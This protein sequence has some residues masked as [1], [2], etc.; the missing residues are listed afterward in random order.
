MAFANDISRR[1]ARIRCLHQCISCLKQAGPLPE[2]LCYVP[3]R[4]EYKCIAGTVDMYP[5]PD[6]NTDP[7]DSMTGVLLSRVIA[8]GH[9][10]CNNQG[11]WIRVKK[12]KPRNCKKFLDVTCESWVLLYGKH[13]TTED[14]PTMEPVQTKNYSLAKFS[15]PFKLSNWEEVV[16][17]HY[18]VCLKK[19]EVAHQDE[20]IMEKLHTVLQNWTLEND[21]ALVQ[22]MANSMNQNS[23]YLGSL[24]NFVDFVDVS[25]YCISDDAGPVNLT[26]DDTG[27]YWESEGSQGQHWIKLQ[28]KKGTIIKKLFLT[29]SGADDIYLPSKVIVCGGEEFNMKELNMVTLERDFFS[30]SKLF[31]YPRL[32]GYTADQLYYRAILLQRFIS[33]LDSVLHYLIPKWNH[34][35]QPILDLES[36]R[37]L[38]PL[39]QMKPVLIETFLRETIKERPLDVRIIF[40]NRRSATEHKSDPSK[41]PECKSTIFMQV[42]EGLQPREKKNKPLNYRW[43]N[44]HDQWWECKFLMEGIIDQ[45]GGFRDSLSDIAEE[46]CPSSSDAPVP[47]PFFIRSPNQIHEDS[48]V[49]RDAYIPNPSCTWFAEYEWIGQLMGACFRSKENLVLSLAPFV[50]KQLSGENISWYQDFTTVDAAEVKL[51][52]TLLNLDE[53]KFPQENRFWST[54]LSNGTEVNLRLQ[55]LKGL[56]RVIPEDV[57][58]LITWQELEKRICGEAE[59]SLEALQKSVHLIDLEQTDLRVKYFWEAV[60]NFSNEDRSRLLRFV[61]GRRRL[62]APL[63]LSSA[64]PEA[65]NALPES[66]TCGNMLFMPKYS[67][68]KLAEEK[69]QYA[70]YN[71]IAIDTD[72]SP[73][74]D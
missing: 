34:Q 11:K 24:A 39:S 43:P 4:V 44:K 66:S 64:K 42:Y 16:E 48:N 15:K 12:A 37:Q 5:K 25:S 8:S 29:L 68:A 53:E 35:H 19:L 32:E 60:K 26:D 20:E 30:K 33:L 49:N 45:G 51:L 13:S 52:E 70:A 63:Y 55:P 40:I 54:T 3:D 27:T 58:R 62:P 61:T 57:L 38:L 31:R 56:L 36:I 22:L 21:E 9:E 69:L 41:D 6:L 23:Q 18:A 2:S 7:I 74:D 46:L 47:L 59:I 72:V 28:M 73:W 71:C 50:W 65:D 17:H 67:S 1:L 10:F 14:M